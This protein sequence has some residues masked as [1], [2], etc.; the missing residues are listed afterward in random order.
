MEN[1]KICQSCGMP[2]TKDEEFGTN[3]GGSKN[4]EFCCYCFKN[5]AFTADCTMEEMIDFCAS[6][7]GLFQDKE[8]AKKEMRQ[9]FPKLKRWAAE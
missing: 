5:G 7:P 2:M 1:Q 9:S 3:A 8:Q 4:E 6:V